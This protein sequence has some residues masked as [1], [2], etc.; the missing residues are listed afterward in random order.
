MEVKDFTGLGQPLTKLLE[1]IQSGCGAIF[2]PVQIRRLARAKADEY[3]L[4]ANAKAEAQI[5]VDEILNKQIDVS[6]RTEVPQGVEG[7]ASTRIAHVEARR[8]ANIEE[9]ISV[10][11]HQLPNEVSKEKPDL[12]WIGRFF[13]MASEVTEPN[14]QELW[15]RVLAGE[16]TLPGRFSL[17]TLEVLRNLS[18]AEAEA[19][20]RAC[21]LVFGQNEFI[22]EIPGKNIN[23]PLFVGDDE[24]LASFGIS[25][26]DRLMLQEAGLI[27]EGL[28]LTID[29]LMDRPSKLYNNGRWIQLSKIKSEKSVS[30]EDPRMAGRIPPPIRL[31]TEIKSL[32]VI[33]FTSAGN[34][35]GGLVPDNYQSAYIELL[36][37]RFKRL[38]ILIEEAA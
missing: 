14:M 13:D 25:L 38:G 17:R 9:I 23:G 15:G 12:T 28:V 19:F 34:A 21:A 7:R 26:G 6:P 27:I 10:A 36:A 37:E 11:A 32:S 20:G 1:I 3:K 33:K 8:Q 18:R 4:L 31:S 29:K 5:S 16:T 2:E 30:P 22:L 24:A 35:L